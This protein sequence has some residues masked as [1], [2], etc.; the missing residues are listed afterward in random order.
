MAVKGQNEGIVLELV[1]PDPA[2]LS[3]EDSKGNTPLHTATNKGRIKV[4]SS[5]IP[6]PLSFSIYKNSDEL[7]FAF[8]CR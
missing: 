1:K 4:S 2:I 6:P 5:L 3:V 7:H 8:A